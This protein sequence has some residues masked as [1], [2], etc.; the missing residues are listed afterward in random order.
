MHV[1]VWGGGPGTGIVR[2]A[3]LPPEGV[4]WVF[5]SANQA[6]NSILV[7]SHGLLMLMID[8]SGLLQCCI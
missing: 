5:C 2:S 6:T 4:F 8:E 1:C 3:P 7:M